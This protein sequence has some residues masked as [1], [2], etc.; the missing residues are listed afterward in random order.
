MPVKSS[1]F[2]WK[3]VFTREV[4][5]AVV[6]LLATALLVLLCYGGMRISGVWAGL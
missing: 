5:G 6:A 1:F 3:L 2:D 4:M